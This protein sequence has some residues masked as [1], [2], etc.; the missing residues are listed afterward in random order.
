MAVV[1][2]PRLSTHQSQK[3]DEHHSARESSISRLHSMVE[4]RL[5]K[6]SGT[7]E[8]VS[9]FLAPESGELGLSLTLQ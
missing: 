4:Q 9:G 8:N 2:G 3:L 1:T 7:T 6:S 5:A